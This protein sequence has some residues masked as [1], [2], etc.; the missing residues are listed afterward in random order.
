MTRTFARS[1]VASGIAMLCLVACALP[2]SAGDFGIRDEA[3]DDPNYDFKI[4]TE[5]TAGRLSGTAHELVYE[6]NNGGRKLSE[7]IWTMDDVVVIGGKV[8]VRPSHWWSVEMGGYI[9]ATHEATMDDYD[10]FYPATTDWTH[11]SHHEDT[12][13]ERALMIDLSTKLALWRTDYFDLQGIAGYRWD[14]FDWTGYGGN[15]TYSTPGNFRDDTG[16]FTPGVPVISYKQEFSAPYIGLGGE[17]RLGDFTMNGSVTGSWWASADDVDNHWLRGLE[18]QESFEGGSMLKYDLEGRYQFTDSL[19][20]K[21]GWQHLDY[22]E[23][24]GPTRISIG[25][26]GPGIAYIPGDSA[27][28]D[29][30]SDIISAGL[31]YSFR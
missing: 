14:K 27:G 15:Y 10:W 30:E 25:P 29:S 21:A 7:L 5:L 19:A 17:L 23:M 20:F 26:G 16:T 2:V 9:N 11:W 1:L 12:S 22:S 13:L 24:K 28:I 8:T 6:P 4:D 3:F 31:V 18:F